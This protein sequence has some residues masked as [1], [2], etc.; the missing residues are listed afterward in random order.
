MAISNG[1]NVHMWVLIQSRYAPGR[2]YTDFEPRVTA[3]FL[4]GAPMHAPT[5]NGK[6]HDPGAW[7]CS[8]VIF[9]PLMVVKQLAFH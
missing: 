3:I 5:R 6:S 7:C 4:N 1:K 2:V 9:V 8:D